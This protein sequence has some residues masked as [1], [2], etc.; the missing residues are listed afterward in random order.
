MYARERTSLSSCTHSAAFNSAAV[1]LLLL[2]VDAS[3]YAVPLAS[4]PIL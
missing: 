4:W 1:L 2:L 3:I